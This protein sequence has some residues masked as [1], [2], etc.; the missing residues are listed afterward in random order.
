VR[1]TL[2][3]AEIESR[4]LWKPMHLQPQFAG[5]PSI[6]GTVSA[7]LFARGVTL[8][9]NPNQPGF[10]ERVGTALAD[11]LTRQRGTPGP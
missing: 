2:A 8:P 11:V 4:P 9:S 7:D 6:G 10:H 1:A 3:A 5:A